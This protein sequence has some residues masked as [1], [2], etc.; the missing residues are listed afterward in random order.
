MLCFECRLDLL[1]LDERAHPDL[2]RS[3]VYEHLK[4]YCSKFRPLPAVTISQASI[5]PVIVEGHKY[6]R[7]AQELG[8]DSIRTVM[9]DRHVH[10]R[11]NKFLSSPGI[12]IIDR[13][14]IDKELWDTRVLDAW[15]I[16]FFE[17]PLNDRAKEEFKKQLTGYFELLKSPLLDS[18]SGARVSEINFPFNDYCAE[19]KAITPVGDESWYRDYLGTTIDFSKRVAAITSYQGYRFMF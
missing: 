18:R 4:H 6:Y 15:H 13:A 1:I 11:L 19:F 5:P 2:D 7:I 17:S 3:Y 10:R 9:A 14:E 16:Y 12:R 8:H